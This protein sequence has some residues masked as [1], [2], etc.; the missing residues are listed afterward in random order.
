MD[1]RLR[2]LDACANRV[3]E[4]LR[5][6]EDVARFRIGDG[7]LTSAIKCLRHELREVMARGGVPGGELGLL[8]S[9]DT[10]GDVGTGVKGSGEGE[11]TGL[12]D[13]A[14]AAARRAGEG[15]RTLE[16][17]AK[18]LGSD[19]RGASARS[20]PAAPMWSR[21]ESLR[22]RLYEA[23]RRLALAMGTGRAPQWRL[24]VLITEALCRQPW[25]EVARECLD[26]G[27]ERGADCLQLREP[28]LRDAELLRRATAL[29]R[30]AEGTGSP[31]GR[32]ALI[33]NDRVDIALASGADGVHLGTDDLP[34]GEARALCGDRL[35]IGASTHTPEE[36]GA[37]VTAGADYCGVGAMFASATKVR[38]VSGPDYLLA[39][40][41][42]F[43]HVPHLAIGGITADN[44]GQ[45]VAAGAR[46]LAVSASVCG[47]EHPGET[48]RRIRAIVDS[49]LQG[50]AERASS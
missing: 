16:E 39:Y 43:P 42:S 35:L 23:E 20:E 34:I 3:R 25:M 12:R 7:G 45:L 47:A 1:P 24:C 29:R 26:G 38:A 17:V 32:A 14:L 6:M 40:L 27:I 9:R 48:C 44:A 30:L 19:A 37:A 4:A 11:R 18:T 15:L 36:A 31:G 28:A 41:R 50:G 33:V 10:P 8:A 46:G 49:A 5:T 2:I 22:Y 21:L 13:V